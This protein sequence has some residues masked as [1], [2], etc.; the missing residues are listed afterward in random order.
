MTT[1]N[2]T[3]EIVKIDSVQTFL[4]SLEDLKGICKI[5]SSKIQFF[6]G[7][8]NKE[9]VTTPSIYREKKWIDNEDAMI[10]E[11]ITRCPNDFKEHKYF[12]QSL[13]K[14]QHHSLPTRLLDITTNPLIALYFSC[15]KDEENDG[16]IIPITTYKVNVKHY[17]SDTVS[18]IANIANMPKTFSINSTINAE[19]ETAAFN[20]TKTIKLLLNQIQREKPHF[21]PRINPGHIESAVF[22][23]P[24]L[25]NQRIIKQDSAFILFGINKSKID[26]ADLTSVIHESEN[27]K[28]IVPFAHKEKIL[29]ELE[30]LGISNGTIFPEVDNVAKY[31]KEKYQ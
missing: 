6:R 17:N 30:I 15:L 10:N 25:D 20:S 27:M 1:P 11:L 5:N 21:E 22:V 2:K 3:P 4:K 31:I 9:W 8:A 14:M 13:V 18:V 24:L 16:E 28:L 7:H 26:P 19:N 12:F 23:R 29:Q